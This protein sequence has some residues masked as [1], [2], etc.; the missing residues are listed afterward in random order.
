[1][2][3]AS[4][5]ELLCESIKT[6]AERD[7]GTSGLPGSSTFDFKSERLPRVPRAFKPRGICS[8]IPGN[9]YAKK[10]PSAPVKTSPE[11]SK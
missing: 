9:H 8:L 6:F 5:P 3:F 1:M 2:E 4:R 7:C 11:F 10:N